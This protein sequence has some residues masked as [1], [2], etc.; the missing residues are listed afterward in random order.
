LGIWWPV[1]VEAAILRRPNDQTWVD[2]TILDW[3]KCRNRTR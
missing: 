3:G 1:Y 2:R